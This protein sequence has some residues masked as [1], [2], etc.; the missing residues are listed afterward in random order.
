MNLLVRF[1]LFIDELEEKNFYRV[2]FATLACAI[3]VIGLLL[4]W[5][6]SRVDY[7]TK[8]LK[9]INNERKTARLL[10]ERHEM[11]KQQKNEVDAILAQDK[12]FKIKE[13]FLR[14]IAELHLQS[15]LSK[16][17]EISEPQDLGNGYDEIKLDASFTG[18]SMQELVELL[19]KIEQ[20]NRIYTQ[21]L[22]ITKA[23]QGP[24]IDVALVIA[25]LLPRPKE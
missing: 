13:Y 5:Q 12:T 22:V 1:K 15:K 3:V 25:T 21:E 16:D 7:W 18:I 2:I 14:V 11:V 8:E 23:S 4:Y 24:T 17:A 10:L 19:Y 6:K 9:R 20:N